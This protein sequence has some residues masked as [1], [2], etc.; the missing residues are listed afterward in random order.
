MEQESIGIN[1]RAT[2]KLLEAV[3]ETQEA[4]RRQ[5]GHARGVDWISVMENRDLQVVSFGL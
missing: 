1:T 3:Y 2:R 5:Y 4:H